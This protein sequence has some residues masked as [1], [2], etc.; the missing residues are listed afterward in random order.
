MPHFFS[1]QIFRSGCILQASICSTG[2]IQI[3]IIKKN[4]ITRRK[5]YRCYIRGQKSSNFH[6]S[7]NKNEFVSNPSTGDLK[8]FKAFPSKSP[9]KP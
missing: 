2:S 1:A 7:P 8:S 4:R 3:K 5:L 6:E 9:H